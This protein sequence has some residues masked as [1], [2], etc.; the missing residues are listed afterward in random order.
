[1]VLLGVEWGSKVSLC[2]VFEATIVRVYFQVV[3]FK[4][5]GQSSPQV[6]VCRFSARVGRVEVVT[7]RER[8]FAFVS[9][10][11]LKVGRS[12]NAL[13]E[14]LGACVRVVSI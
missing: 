1:M 5:L 11:V 13:V 9:K 10:G 2:R 8:K 12:I 4:A 7:I 3:K 14:H 6:S